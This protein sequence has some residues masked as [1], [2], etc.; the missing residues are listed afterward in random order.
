MSRPDREFPVSLPDLKMILEEAAEIVRELFHQRGRVEKKSD[1][2][3]LT[4]ADLRANRFLRTRLLGLLPGVG[5]I[6]EEGAP[7]EGRLDRPGIW[8]VDPLD[9]TKEFARGIPELAISIGLV[10]D[11]QVVAAGVINPIT[12][13][14][15]VGSSRGGSRV[16]GVPFSPEGG[17]KPRR[18]GGRYQPERNR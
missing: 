18:G 11:H 6:S 10:K 4:P 3:P 2:S 16:L 12:G 14:G 7:D 17:P 5:W 1:G 8:I 9:G 13:E 15:G